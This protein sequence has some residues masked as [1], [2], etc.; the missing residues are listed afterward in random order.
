MNN[1]KKLF[2]IGEIAKTIGITRRIILNY[3]EKGL[4]TYDVKKGENGNR[5][6]TMDTFAKIHTI[7]N[8]QNLGL[9]LD[10]IHDYLEDKT[11]LMLMIRRLEGIRDTLELN[12]EKL[13]ERADIAAEKVKKITVRK[14]K[15]YCRTY[16][17]KGIPEKTELLRKTALEATRIYGADTTG[18][19]YFTEY[20]FSSPEI[21]SFCASVP[22]DSEGE[23]IVTI[24]TFPAI[25]IYHHG[26]YEKLPEAVEKL[27]KYAEKN[28]IRI[29]DKYRFAFLEGPPQ[30]N[31][32]N[33]FITQ[34]IIPIKEI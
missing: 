24:P 32:K 1:E 25:C 21:S 2:S 19:M 20:S 11:D 26:A 8:F 31:D 4:I 27:V 13:Y 9:S 23:N 15:I 17:A 22:P 28:K 10:E 3:E 16:A 18:R 7:R 34:V 6:Y 30:H 14:Q 33:K 5:Y 12:I 29:L